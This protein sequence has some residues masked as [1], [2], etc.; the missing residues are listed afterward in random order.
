ML[1]IQISRHCLEKI[2]ARQG[3][4]KGN[5]AKLRNESEGIFIFFIY[6]EVKWRRKRWVF[7]CCLK[8]VRDSAFW[9]RV[10]SARTFV[11]VYVCVCVRT[12]AE[13]CCARYRECDRVQVKIRISWKR[14]TFFTHF[15]KRKPYLIYT[16]QKC[17]FAPIFHELNFIYIALLT[18]QIVTKHCTI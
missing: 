8:I 12:G 11:C 1:V 3:E 13:L 2:L 16:E 7:R 15:R 6:D 17:I 5:R 4:V 18:I 9:M 14:S 10:G